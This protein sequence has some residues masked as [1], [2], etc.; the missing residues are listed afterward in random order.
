LY[1]I[2]YIYISIV[3]TIHSHLP[4]F[5]HLY[6]S[7]SSWQ[8]WNQKTLLTLPQIFCSPLFFLLTC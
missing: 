3:V 5:S 7:S 1:F 4:F 6:I 2:L 8:Q